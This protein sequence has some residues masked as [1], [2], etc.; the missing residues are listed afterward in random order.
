M[1]RTSTQADLLNPVAKYLALENGALT[2]KLDQMRRE[3]AEATRRHWEQHLEQDGRIQEQHQEIEE[4]EETIQNY[5]I[6]MVTSRQRLMEQHFRIIKMK[7]EYGELVTELFQ[8]RRIAA[9]LRASLRWLRQFRNIEEGE[10][11]TEEE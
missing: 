4:M 3:H 1:K 6:T 8:E 5:E 11:E 10:T 9:E 2:R 7:K